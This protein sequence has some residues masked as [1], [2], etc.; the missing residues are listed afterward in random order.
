MGKGIFLNVNEVENL[1]NLFG[2][3]NR[4]KIIVK[5]KNWSKNNMS[6]TTTKPT[7]NFQDVFLNNLRKKKIPV[8]IYLVNGF[9]I[10]GIVHGFDN[11]SLI[12]ENNGKQ[13][14]VYKL[15]ISTISSVDS[16]SII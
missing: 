6:N 2:S 13:Q 16:I 3:N 11:Y 14:I 12:I 9:Q 15:V 10:R 1:M 8:V 7:I 5:V 4:F